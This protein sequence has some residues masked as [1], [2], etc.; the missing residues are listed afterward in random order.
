[1]EQRIRLTL[2]F[3]RG[4]SLR[5]WDDGG[6]L[7]REVAIY[8]RLLDRGIAVNFVTYGNAQ[9]LE[10]RKRL[11]GIRILCNRWNLSPERYERWL[12]LLHA[13]SFAMTDVI[14]TNQTGGSDIALRVSRFWKKPLIARCGFMLSHNM[15]RDLGEDSLEAVSAREL[16][17]KVFTAANK[18]IV[19]TEKMRDDVCGRIPAAKGKTAVLPNY[20][21]TDLFRPSAEDL[22][23][24]VIFIGRLSPEKNLKSLLEASSSLNLRIA[25][26]GGGR[27]HDELKAA[28]PEGRVRWLGNL[29]NS[30][31]PKYMN[32]SRV[33]VLP[34]F[35]EGHPK[36]LLEAMSCGMPVIGA[37]SPGIRELLH[38]GENGL[39]CGTGPEAIRSALQKLLT[40]PELRNTL[41][42]NARRFVERNFSLDKII[43]QE[44]STYRE[45]LAR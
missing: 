27:L 34:S 20:V 36:A 40:D 7:E 4:V 25:V 44:I 12:P 42:A 24:D 10:Y 19:T 5:I 31:L 28:H 16:E 26:V 22:D 9:E 43:E 2:F 23:Y 37:D 41:G 38:S 3:T 39:L 11:P 45:V 30:E 8:R 21:D 14:K 6:M 18:V 15:G 33:F 1:M 32:R 13:V 29:P 17:R 35:Y